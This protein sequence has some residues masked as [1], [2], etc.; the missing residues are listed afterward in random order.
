M[1]NLFKRVFSILAILFITLG[2]TN[3]AHADF[4]KE[5]LDSYTESINYQ[6]LSPDNIPSDVLDGCKKIY[7]AYKAR[8]L[9]NTAAMAGVSNNA[10]ESRCTADAVEVGGGGGFGAFQYTGPSL[11]QYKSWANSN[12]KDYT[13]L[14]TQIQYWFE[15]Y[16]QGYEF[17]NSV[18]RT[19]TR[20]YYCPHADK[21]IDCSKMD[22]YFVDDIDGWY[23]IDDVYVSTLFFQSFLERSNWTMRHSTENRQIF[24]NYFKDIIPEGGV[25]TSTKGTAD[26]SNTFNESSDSLDL[27]GSGPVEAKDL[28]GYV[29]EG[30]VEGGKDIEIKT[31]A[32]LTDEESNVLATN[33]EYQ[34]FKQVGFLQFLH[35]G[36]TFSGLLIILYSLVFLVSAILDYNNNLLKVQ[37]LPLV[38][39][40]KYRLAYDKGSVIK[41][42]G[43]LLIGSLLGRSF[44]IM[45]IGIIICT[46]VVTGLVASLLDR[47][48]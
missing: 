4:S 6:G 31:R 3:T 26:N 32:D 13:K 45:V 25:S 33:Q 40:G 16:Y 29:E 19:N 24:A 23:K 2:I 11:I 37:I 8:G 27:S 36:I 21:F 34:K 38:T 46:G 47:L 1:N 5:E 30:K 17:R 43:S 12:G 42:E 41:E 9:S 15:G 14:D 7:N 22:S 48:V 35:I 20:I 10:E 44:I 18:L 28:T 39:L